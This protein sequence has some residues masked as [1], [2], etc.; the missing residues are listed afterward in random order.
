VK[1]RFR[2]A[3]R[4]LIQFGERSGDINFRFSSRSSAM[5]GIRGH[6]KVQRSRAAGYVA[7]KQVAARWSD[8][9]LEVDISGRVDGYFPDHN[10]M[11]VEEIKTVRIDVSDLPTAVKR[12]HWGQAMVYAWLLAELHERQEV[13]VRLV[14]LLLP[15]DREVCEERLVSR[16][17][18]Q[19]YYETMTAR[20][21]LWL[22]NL[23]RWYGVRDASIELLE[24]PYGAYR[25]GQR[26]MAV[27]VYRALRQQATLVMQAPTG[28]GKTMATLYPA[29]KGLKALGYDKV[30]FLTAKN[31]GQVAAAQAVAALKT[32]GLELLDVTLTAKDK[33]CFTKGAPCHPDHCDYARGYYDRIGAVLTAVVGRNA[34]FSR[35]AVEQ[36]ARD[37]SL[38]PFELS[39]D[40]STIADVII[41]DYNY[42][43]DPAVYLRRHFDDAPGQHALLIDEA[44]NLVDRGR[45]MF[46]ATLVNAGFLALLR[47]DQDRLK[48][49]GHLRIPALPARLLQSLRT[50]CDHA[51]AVLAEQPQ[52]AFRELLLTQYFA[53]LRF[54][55]TAEWF[56]EH[57]ACLL[58]QDDA[59]VTL[60]L[61]NLNPAPGLTKAMQRGRANVCFSAT[62]SP[63]SYFQ[64][65]LGIA[66]ETPWYGIRSPFDAGNL[67]IYTVPFVST[68]YRD[69]AA[70]LSTLV[71]VIHDVVSARPG[72]YLA[73]FPSHVYLNQA[74]D[75]FRARYP[76]ID[77]IRQSARMDNDER[78][79][80]LVR[81]DRGSDA[82]LVGF[83]VLGG[84]FGEG[85]DL[86]GTRL[87]GVIVAGVGLP[88]ICTERD[89]I[90]DYFEQKA[91]NG[92][93]FRFAYQSPGMNK[94]LQT[95][96][97]VIR[98]ESDRGIVCLIDRRYAEAGYRQLLPES[99]R[100]EEV[101]TRTELAH[102][103][104]AF[105][106]PV[107]SGQLS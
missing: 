82:P 74:F 58:Q 34:S 94:V 4:E 92:A 57:Y 78:D 23:C 8:D 72:N 22:H 81:F 47:S 87:I 102:S 40:L 41:C 62:L 30:F 60:R 77:L 48:S 33:I 46:S 29:I 93:G 24:F 89:M 12:T 105:W 88:Q 25:E 27:S 68:A 13:I 1:R 97:R 52:A 56:D 3:V 7:E 75:A 28:I 85:I 49:S 53:C 15:E 38:C 50:F 99:W 84:V 61:W 100:V 98:S 91:G 67:G 65:L 35:E 73:F 37:E 69:R 39:L 106:N 63:Q 17:D 43:F 70:S 96:G 45:E 11:E 86:V 51:E 31:S 79:A 76:D 103:L 32:S 59:G 66:P 21:A 16:S 6:Q 9:G 14:Y 55:R 44:H 20:Y 10:P 64:P 80:F 95:A 104:R 36:L 19:D 18:L 2:V 54:Q 5:A 71:A 107:G 42:V 26:A 101:A 90:R 83:A